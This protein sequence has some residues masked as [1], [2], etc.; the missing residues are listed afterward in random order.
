MERTTSIVDAKKIMGINFIGQ[1]ELTSI[2]DQMDINVPTVIPKIPFSVEG[3]LKKQSN[4]ILILGA[5]F[6]KS[7]EPLTLNSLRSHFGYNPEISEPCFY[8]QDWYLN[9]SFMAISLKPTWFL[10]RKNIFEESRG[11]N[12]EDIK[13]L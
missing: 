8:N 2:A 1:E 11:R 9:E 13:N 7:G 6:M 5:T 12:P 10:I 3:L 4:Y